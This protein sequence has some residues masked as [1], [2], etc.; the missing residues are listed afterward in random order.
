MLEK[1][2]KATIKKLF[3]REKF[4]VQNSLINLGS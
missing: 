3:D 2:T 4:N 1:N